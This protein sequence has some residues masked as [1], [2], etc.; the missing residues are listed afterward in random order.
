LFQS[1]GDGTFQS[2]GQIKTDAAV[3]GTISRREEKCQA[4]IA[5]LKLSAWIRRSA[6]RAALRR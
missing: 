3:R 5:S 1:Q 4:G 6:T 2:V